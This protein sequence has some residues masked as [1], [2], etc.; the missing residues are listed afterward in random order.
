MINQDSG[1]P[2]SQ[3]SAL[4]AKGEHELEFADSNTQAPPPMP[5]SRSLTQ[6]LPQSVDAAYCAYVTQQPESELH[7][8][9][10]LRGQARKII[11]PRLPQPDEALAHDIAVRTMQALSTFRGESAFS[12]WF[13]AIAKNEA[14]RALK[15]RIRTRQREVPIEFDDEDDERNTRLPAK[16]PDMDYPVLWKEL[17]RCLPQEQAEVLTMQLEGYSLE[18]ITKRTGDPLGTVRSRH[19]LAKEKIKKK[20]AGE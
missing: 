17:V 3:R 13:W 15:D 12:T 4:E 14:N 6:C 16:L 2:I 20:S 11:W 5:R 18:E 7:L 9:K 1:E 19:R 10:A 8:Y